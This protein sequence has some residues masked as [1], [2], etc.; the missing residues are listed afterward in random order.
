MITC[1]SIVL[2]LVTLRCLARQS[3][4]Y[5]PIGPAVVHLTE[6]TESNEVVEYA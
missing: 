4:T 2:A 5:V 1:C 6:I 3:I